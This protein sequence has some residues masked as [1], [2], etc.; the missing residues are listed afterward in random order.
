MFCAIFPE[1]GLS[2]FIVGLGPG[3]SELELLVVA[4]DLNFCFYFVESVDEV[5][6]AVGL[7]GGLSDAF[8]FLL[9]FDDVLIDRFDLGFDFDFDFFK[10]VEELILRDFTDHFLLP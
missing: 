8:E 5:G 7:L 1:D 2:L 6:E 4:Q 9:D 3:G 10:Q